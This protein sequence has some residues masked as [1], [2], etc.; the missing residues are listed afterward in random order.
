MTKRTRHAGLLLISFGLAILLNGN[1]S[2][3]PLG[4]ETVALGNPLTSHRIVHRN[5]TQAERSS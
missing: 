3:M 4:P 5:F 2:H 1:P